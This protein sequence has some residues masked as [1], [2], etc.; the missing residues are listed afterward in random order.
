MNVRIRL[1][2]QDLSHWLLWR[3]FRGYR[4]QQF[5][6]RGLDIAS[7]AWESPEGHSNVTA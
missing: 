7:L 2:R 1:S 5:I 3:C 6:R 4:R